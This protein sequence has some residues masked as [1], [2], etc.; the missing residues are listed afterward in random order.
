MIETKTQTYDFPGKNIFEN[1]TLISF[2][3]QQYNFALKIFGFVFRWNPRESEVP[4]TAF[5]GSRT[6]KKILGSDPWYSD[7]YFKNS[8]E[9]R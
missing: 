4:W 6:G 8:K 3:L 2:Y 7:E 1:Y 5:Q 9:K